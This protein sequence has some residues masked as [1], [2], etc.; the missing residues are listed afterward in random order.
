MSLLKIAASTREPWLESPSCLG[1]G[2][3]A[4]RVVGR[5]SKAQRVVFRGSKA[6]RVGARRAGP[7]EVT[8]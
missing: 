8:G 3:N 7:R 5:G 6:Q 2:S 1:R 4:R